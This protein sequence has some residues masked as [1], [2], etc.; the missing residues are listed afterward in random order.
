M[1]SVMSIPTA[2]IVAAG[3][4]NRLRPLTDDRPKCLLPVG[5]TTILERSLAQIHRAGIQDVVI[6]RGYCGD[7]I[8]APAV[9]FFDNEQFLHNNI[10]HSL[11]CAEAAMDG[12][13]LFSYGDIVYDASVLDALLAS[14]EDIAVVVD[15]EWQTAYEGRDLHMEDEAEVVLDDDAGIRLIGKGAVAP[16]RAT[17]EFIGMAKFSE[18]GA[19][20]LRDEFHRLCARYADRFE[21]PFQRAKE[22]RKAYMTD[23]F[24]ELIDRGV[25]VAAVPIRGGWREIDTPQDLERAQALFP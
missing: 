21:T 9:R 11:F 2:I 10:L 14:P 17:G 23:M 6:V 25:R 12:G 7:K 19:A 15:R 24:Q 16:V 13:F 3:M 5:G 22:F 8:A 4:G 20:T 1:K 18:R